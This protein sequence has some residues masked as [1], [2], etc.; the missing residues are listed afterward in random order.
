M[1][2]L[3]SRLSLFAQA[4]AARTNALNAKIVELQAMPFTHSNPAVI[5]SGL[6]VPADCNALSVGPLAI[7]D[8][9]EVVIGDGANWS[10]V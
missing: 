9:V 3:A 4:V 8:G 7:A 5:T 1:M 10:V 6:T 2:T